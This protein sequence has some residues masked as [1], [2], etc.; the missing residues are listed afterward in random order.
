MP[1]TLPGHIVGFGAVLNRMLIVLFFS[2]M[3]WHAIRRIQLCL[4]ATPLGTIAPPRS[5]VAFCAKTSPHHSTTRLLTYRAWC[6]SSEKHRAVEHACD[7]LT[8]R[9][10][11]TCIHD[12]EGQILWTLCWGVWKCEQRNGAHSSLCWS[13]SFHWERHAANRSSLL[14]RLQCWM[15]GIVFV[16]RAAT[17]C[18][19]CVMCSNAISM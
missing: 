3:H 14:H 7:K 12:E 4:K 6:R 5:I 2:E 15:I 9:P 11:H 13:P 10:Q 1:Q 16:Y 8:S 18:N 17:H 19:K